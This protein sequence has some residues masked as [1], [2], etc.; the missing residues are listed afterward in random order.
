MNTPTT[1]EK[2]LSDIR[3]LLCVI[4]GASVV[5]ALTNIYLAVIG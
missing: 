3:L 1:T 5:T 4:A 2:F